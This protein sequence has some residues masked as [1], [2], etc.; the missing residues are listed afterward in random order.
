MRVDERNAAPLH[1]ESADTA[2]V[3]WCVRALVHR[4]IFAMIAG[5]DVFCDDV[6]H[7]YIL[8]HA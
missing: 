2:P 8:A 4:A 5:P 1:A 7:L 6:A 3:G